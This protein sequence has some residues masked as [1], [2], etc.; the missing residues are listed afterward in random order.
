[1][2]DERLELF[3]DLASN[4]PQKSPQLLVPTPPLALCEVCVI[5]PVRNEAQTIETTLSALAYQIDLKGNKLDWRRYEVILLANNC[6]DNSAEIACY[7][8][9]RHPELVLHVVEITL[10][11]AEAYIG[12]VRQIL[13]DEAYRRLVYLRRRRGI[14]ASTDGDSQVTPT[15]IAA[16]IAEVAAGADA[17]G[18]RIY[19]TKSDRAT[20]NPY[21]KACYLREV[22]YRFL[23]AELEDYLDPDPDDRFPRHYQHYGASLAVTAQMYQQA[24][25]LPAVRTPEDVA[26]YQALLRVNARFRHSPLVKV[27][28]SARETGRAALGLAN[29]LHQW[30]AMGMGE[31]PFLVESV[32]AI[33]LRLQVR[34]Q[35]R[36]LWSGILDG[37]QPDIAH[38]AQIATDLGVNVQWLAKELTQPHTFGLLFEKIEQRQEKEGIWAQ[39]WQKVEI[40]QVITELRIYLD[41]LRKKCDRYSLSK[42]PSFS[43]QDFA[44]L[45]AERLI[46]F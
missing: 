17:V 37:Y 26:F 23:I 34:H 22:G 8:A 44:N 35:L 11:P 46:P 19:I 3:A 1:M 6:S 45:Q 9:R 24:G 38:I 10:P 28:T 14:I 15:W 4:L 40:R 16:N 25:G 39:R 32:N 29:Q 12:R 21:A 20:L 42:L 13:M 43:A 2:G 27:V 36:I 41:E 18:G 5:V 33:A 7:F 31:Q 30:A